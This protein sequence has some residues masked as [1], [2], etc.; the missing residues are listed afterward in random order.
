[1][2]LNGYI[3][4]P[5]NTVCNSYLT[6]NVILVCNNNKQSTV[7]IIINKSIDDISFS[8]LSKQLGFDNSQYD[9]Q[10][11]EIPLYFG[12]PEEISRG[13]V[14]H[15]NDVKNYYNTI[16]IN[17]E[18]NLTSS[19]DILRDISNGRCPRN[20][21]IAI[22]IVMWQNAEIEKEIRSNVWLTIKGT[23]ENVFSCAQNFNREKLLKKIGV[24]DISSLSCYVG[25]S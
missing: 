4:I 15:T 19:V 2:D 9:K 3:L 7:G 17:N 11:Q 20:Y 25:R 21:L 13:F 1:M 16:S 18:I 23:E 8:T 14:L 10:N 5:T 24:R 12:G 6:D 22:G